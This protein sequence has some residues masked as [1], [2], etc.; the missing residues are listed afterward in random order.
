MF[1]WLS[2]LFE[3]IESFLHLPDLLFS[4]WSAIFRIL[5]TTIILYFALVIFMKLFG[6]RSVSSFSVYDMIATITIGSVVSSTMLLKEVNLINGIIAVLG[7]LILQFFLSAI[8]GK[9]EKIYPVT[10]PTPKV[11]FLDGEYISENMK[12]TRVNK[13]EILSAIRRE[14]GTTSDQIYAVLLEANGDLSV[15]QE[16]TPGYE[17]EIT[18]Y[19]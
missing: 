10:N 15:I 11:V 3:Q 8:V 4:N 14:A 2:D 16:V 13:E 19:L 6:S 12:K 1:S 17:E 18:K 9:W 5:L 7:L